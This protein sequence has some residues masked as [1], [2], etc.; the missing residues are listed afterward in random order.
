MS[1]AHQAIDAGA[2]LFVTTGNHNLGA[3]ELYRSPRRGVRPIFYGLGNFFWSDVQEVMP[4]D[5]YQDNRALLEQA[6]H[7]PARAT[8]YDLTAPLNKDRFAHAF[9]FQ[10]V[11]AVSRFENNEVSEVELQAVEG[12]YGEKLTRSG[13]PRRVLDAKA[14]AAIYQQIAEANRRFGLPILDLRL[15]GASAR[16]RATH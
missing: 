12:G 7:D 1:L 3:L 10:S 14:A 15:E 16:I 4:H 8:G 11:I 5:L 6:W 9:T 13:I 2:D